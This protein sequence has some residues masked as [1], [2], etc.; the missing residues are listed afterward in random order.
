MFRVDVDL[1]GTNEDFH[2]TFP[3][4]TEAH[5][6]IT[7]SMRDGYVVQAKAYGAV[8]IYHPISCV[9]TMKISVPVAPQAFAPGTGPR[10]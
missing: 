1:I 7:V 8:K 2:V 9:R 10:R 3:T 5:D 6:Y 4:E